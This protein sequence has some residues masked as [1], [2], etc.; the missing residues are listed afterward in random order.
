MASAHREEEDSAAKEVVLLP[1]R[2]EASP[3][4]RPLLHS[5]ED[6]PSLE[7]E[8]ASLPSRWEASPTS[9]PLLHSREDTLSLEEEA[10]SLL[11]LD[12]PLLAMLNPPREEALLLHKMVEDIVEDRRTS[13]LEDMG[14]RPVV[15]MLKEARPVAA[16]WMSLTG[17][18]A[19]TKKYQLPLL[20]L[21][22]HR[23]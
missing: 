17:L 6:T 9:R 16:A 8:V 20:L 13:V 14:D 12:H 21:K 4:N 10:V 5:R 1:S 19:L 11:N 23:L 15:A 7:E 22:F 2:W 18:A 3:V